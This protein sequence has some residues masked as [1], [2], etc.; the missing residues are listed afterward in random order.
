MY[1]TTDL[2]LERLRVKA[3]LEIGEKE[4]L[5]PQYL[6]EL[7]DAVKDDSEL[8]IPN[9]NE[10]LIRF[11]RARK[12]NVDRAA[13]ML[14]KFFTLRKNV[15][16]IAH[17]LRPSKHINLYKADASTILKKRDAKGRHIL[18][19]RVAQWD[20]NK[21]SFDDCLACI[22]LML[23]ESTA[24]LDTQ[25][26]GITVILDFKG[27]GFSHAR[28]IG[29]RRLQ[30]IAS[31]LQDSYPA[32]FKEIHLLNHPSIFNMVFSL[33]KPFLKEKIRKRINFHAYDIASLQKFVSADILPEVIGGRVDN[34][35]FSD[36]ELVKRLLSKDDYYDDLLSYGYDT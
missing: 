12:Y 32:R 13:K 29:P 5:I 17:L 7:R 18:L 30:Q 3:K 22:F 1:D 33:I 23:D 16:D 8:R 27:F 20:T 35:E 19:L 21:Y 4:E 11:L 25:Y 2:E 26:N 9:D 36:T 6:Q 31:L 28:L 14:K 24:T 10:F 15:N 34:D